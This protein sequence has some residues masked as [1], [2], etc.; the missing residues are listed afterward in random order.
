M[1]RKSEEFASLENKNKR[2]KEETSENLATLEELSVEALD[3]VGIEAGRTK[4]LVGRILCF[5]DQISEIKLKLLTHPTL[6]AN[7]APILQFVRSRAAPGSEEDM[8]KVFHVVLHMTNLSEQDIMIEKETI[9]G[10]AYT[11]TPEDLL[12]KGRQRTSPSDAQHT[13]DNDDIVD[14][15]EGAASDDPSSQPDGIMDD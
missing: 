2:I 6:L 1:K 13:I 5:S 9:L 15:S 7:F 3:T 8:V 12:L 10:S 4:S 11:A 14:S